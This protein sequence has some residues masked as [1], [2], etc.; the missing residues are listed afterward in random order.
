V[1]IGERY[2]PKC[3]SVARESQGEVGSPWRSPLVRVISLDWWVY[4]LGHSSPIRFGENP[5]LSRVKSIAVCVIE[6]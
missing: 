3:C 5:R 6:S 1:Y 2:A 4:T